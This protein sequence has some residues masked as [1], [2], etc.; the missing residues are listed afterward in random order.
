RIPQTT[1]STTGVEIEGA[2]D[3]ETWNLTAPVATG[4]SLYIPAQNVQVPLVIRAS[5]SGT[6]NTRNGRVELRNNGAS[7]GSAPVGVS[8]TGNTLRTWSIPIGNT[9]IAAGD[10]LQMRVV[11]TYAQSNRDIIVV[12]RQSAANYSRLY[13]QTG[14]VINVDEVSTHTAIYPTVNVKDPWNPG[15][16]VYIRADISDPFGGYDV[17]GARLTLTDGNGTTVV[18]NAAMTART[19]PA[20]NGTPNRIYA[21]RYPTP[22]SPK[23]GL[24]TAT[25]TATEGSETA[26]TITHSGIK[27]FTVEPKALQ[28]VKSHSGDFI[29]GANNSY[30]LTVSNTDVATVTGTTTVKDTLATGLTFV[31]GTG[32]GWSCSAVGQVVTC[33]SSTSIPASSSMAPITLTVFVEIGRA[34]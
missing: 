33:T 8:G 9:T 23:F 17:S 1:N 10:Q 13:F 21:Y 4:K 3:Q 5:G 11:N 25:V 14:T 15:D 16:V 6:G 32:T 20:N 7:M 29:A 28:V 34:S 18:N 27:T 26:P 22:A 12:S 30:T 31:S 19:S 24:Y 2:N